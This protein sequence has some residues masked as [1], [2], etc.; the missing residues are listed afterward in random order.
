MKIGIDYG[1]TKI[2]AIALS[3]QGEERARLRVPTP[4]DDYDA[5]IRALRDLVLALEASAGDVAPA[6]GMG[7]PG[8]ISPAT[9]LVRNANSVWLNGRPL[10]RDL[11]AALGRPVRVANDANCFALSEAR[12]GGGA[13]ARIV[14]G[15]ITGTGVGGGVVIDGKVLGGAS[16][17]GGEWGHTPLPRPT[18]AERPGARCWCG[19]CG[20]LEVWLSGPALKADH[21]RVLG[22]PLEDAPDAHAIAKAAAAGDGPA[23]ATLDRHADRFGRALAGMINVIDPHV[24]VLGGGLSNLDGLPERIAAAMAP[25]VFSDVIGAKI[26]RNVHGDSSGVRGA[27]WLWDSEET[28]A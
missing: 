1:G 19:R 5:N 20:C 6:V 28:P 26:M 21:A 22:L 27:A 18:E 11:A 15:S 12:D 25:H 2:E 16:G 10:D 24:V 17:I 14:F 7:I 4:R 13:G 23:R 8:S 3:D 9:G